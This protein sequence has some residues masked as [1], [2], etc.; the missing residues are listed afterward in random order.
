[1]GSGE[2]G[3]SDYERLSSLADF[4]EGLGF[5]GRKKP[6]IKSIEDWEPFY[7]AI[8]ELETISNTGVLNGDSDYDLDLRCCQTFANAS[9]VAGN[10]ELALFLLARAIEI[11]EGDSGLEETLGYLYMEISGVFSSNE[12]YAKSKDYAR[13]SEEIRKKILN[14]E[15]AKEIAEREAKEIAEREV[16]EIARERRLAEDRRIAADRLAM[17]KEEARVERERRL[18]EDTEVGRK[19]DSSTSAMRI[20]NKGMDE[21]E[22]SVERVLGI[23]NGTTFLLA[24]IAILGLFG[25]VLSDSSLESMFSIQIFC[26]A[27]FSYFS[28]TYFFH[29]W[30]NI[31]INTTLS[32]RIQYERYAL[33]ISEEE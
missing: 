26:S 30:K 14:E 2:S 23:Y 1:M 5:V 19:E 10:N 25:V 4:F 15:I 29:M 11:S 17:A 12:E 22:G 9:L 13:K 20:W 31:S 16:K 21:A 6:V 7:E 3:D 8:E 28:L 32:T 33:E 24:I 18:A 27:I